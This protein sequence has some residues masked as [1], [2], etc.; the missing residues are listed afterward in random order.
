VRPELVE[1]LPGGRAVDPQIPAIAGAVGE[2][3]ALTQT[4]RDAH[5]DA[6]RARVCKSYALAP[7]ARRLVSVYD[8]VLER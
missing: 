7:W 3:L 4:E 1:G 6:A 2:V 8:R 5:A